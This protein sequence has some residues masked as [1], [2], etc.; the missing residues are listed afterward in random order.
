MART[1]RRAGTGAG[2]EAAGADAEAADAEAE[3]ITVVVPGIVGDRRGGT[4]L[5]APQSH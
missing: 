3:G 5:V 1:G 2:G 4:G